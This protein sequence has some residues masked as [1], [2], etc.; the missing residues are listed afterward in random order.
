MAGIRSQVGWLLR[1]HSNTARTLDALSVDLRALQE[2]VA[3]MELRLRDLDVGQTAL[4][5]SQLDEFD[6]VREAVAAA[7]DDLSAR[8]AAANG[9]AGHG[10]SPDE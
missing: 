2:K 3:A 7:T 8:I 10:T 5:E 6:R 1:G 9:Q 4:R